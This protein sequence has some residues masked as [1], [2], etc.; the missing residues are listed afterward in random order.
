M[1]LIPKKIYQS[2]KT[3]DIS[4]PT[5]ENVQKIKDLNP[6][7]EYE[8]YD[9]KDCLKFILE[10]FG[11]NYGNAF[12]AL[13]AGAFRSD[14]W[15]YCMLYTYGGVYLDIDMVPLIPFSSLIKDTDKFVSIVDK[16]HSNMIGIYQAFFACIPKHPIL[17]YCIQIAFSNIATRRSALLGEELSITGP[18]VMAVAMN[19][20]WKRKNTNQTIEP[21]YYD[22]DN[23]R[24]YKMTTDYCYDLEGKK[25]FKN[26]FDGYTGSSYG[27]KL[28][29][30]VD[31]PR[32]L[33]KKR[34][35]Y[36]LLGIIILALLGGIFT[37]IY[38]KRLKSCEKSCLVEKI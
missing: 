16:A 15:R 7:Y 11:E 26:Q 24:L 10:N 3:K 38:K 13:S 31:D 4:G 2:W 18:N 5:A 12:S 14:F 23:I 21:G 6:D 30:Y 29:H 36:I 28:T 33:M 37:Y 22:K 1:S 35:L 20:Y 17:L 25:I 9:D 8:L 34:A 27:M 19:L 32:M